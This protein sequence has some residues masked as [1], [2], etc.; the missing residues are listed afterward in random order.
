MNNL[1]SILFIIIVFL[2]ATFY[3]SEYLEEKSPH[4]LLIPQML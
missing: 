1:L 4:R 3:I 2:L